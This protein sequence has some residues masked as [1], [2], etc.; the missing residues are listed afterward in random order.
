MYR[1]YKNRNAR[2]DKLDKSPPR[3]L[4]E[5]R[6]PLANQDFKDIDSESI[7][8]EVYDHLSLKNALLERVIRARKT[9]HT[10]FFSS[11]LDY[12]HQ[13]IWTT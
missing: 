11:N 10:H 1:G 2:L 4:A 3:F 12:G 5:S 9:H 8:H 13:I 7:L 6:T